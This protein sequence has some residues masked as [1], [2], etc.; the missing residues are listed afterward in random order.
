MAWL[1]GWW[2]GNWLPVIF[3][4]CALPTGVGMVLL[5]P[6]GE[7]PDEPQHIS[8]ADGLLSGQIMGA[9]W[10]G[11]ATAGVMMN[12]ALFVATIM[13]IDTVMGKPKPEAALRQAEA[14]RWSDKRYGAAK[15]FCPTQMVR[16]FPAFYVPGSL[17]ILA[18]RV[19]GISPLDSL[20][21][22]RFF[23]LV[24][25]LAMGAAALHLA[26]FGRV[27]LFTVLTLPLAL[28]LAGSFNQDG[29]MIGAAVLAAALLTRP[30]P[31]PNREWVLA[32]LLITLIA[33]A[34][35]PYGWLL[36]ACLPPLSAAGFRER[37]TWVVSAAGLPL[38][39]LWAVRRMSDWPWPR[40]A[41][42]PGPLWPGSRTGWLSTTSA[43]SNLEVLLAHPAQIIWLPAHS[44]AIHFTSI[45]HGMIGALSWELVP[46]PSWQH[47]GWL[48]ALAAALL[49]LLTDPA[50]P[51]KRA[52]GFNALLLLATV[53]SIVLSAYIT[54]TNVGYDSIDGISGRYFL[55][56]LPFLLLALPRLRSRLAAVAAPVFCLPAIIM[57]ALDIY[58]LP[59]Q[60]YHVFQMPGP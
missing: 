43:R 50:A 31:G 26:R 51:E 12:S 19:L 2:R 32:L 33:C 27:L 4:L 54:F 48:L 17:G 9:Y 60:I 13:E 35:A 21:F 1:R 24:S 55:P 37:L 10:H 44:L 56:V 30:R 59:A 49:G 58:A 8:R 23:M 3:L 38:A 29:P 36:F 18:G 11:S 28:D 42:H 14:V 20:F 39:W 7:V 25:F 45:W 15:I 53:L 6:I 40:P 22:G 47:A 41:Y 46:L 34:K 5:T 57:A 52:L 16:Y